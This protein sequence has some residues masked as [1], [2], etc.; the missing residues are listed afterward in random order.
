MRKINRSENIILYHALLL[1]DFFVKNP[2]PGI[3]I[4]EEHVIIEKNKIRIPF[5]V[6]AKGQNLFCVCEIHFENS[7][8]QQ[9]EYVANVFQRFSFFFG[10]M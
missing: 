2:R 4:F 1:V 5:A 8:S 9:R 3:V 10:L 7:I 6:Q